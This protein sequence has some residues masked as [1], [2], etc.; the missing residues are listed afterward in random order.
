MAPYKP[1]QLVE[2]MVSFKIREKSKIIILLNFQPIFRL[3]LLCLTR[4]TIN[5]S[6][7]INKTKSLY[8]KELL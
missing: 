2:C 6:I 3:N 5:V 8:C 7:I 1:R 4:N